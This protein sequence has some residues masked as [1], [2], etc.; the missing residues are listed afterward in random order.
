MSAMSGLT[1]MQ[2][3]HRRRELREE[4]NHGDHT[5]E[6][7]E[8]FKRQM[9]MVQHELDKRVIGSAATGAPK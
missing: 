5:D 7:I 8:G 3:L 6:T 9:D 1:T 4:I 2:L